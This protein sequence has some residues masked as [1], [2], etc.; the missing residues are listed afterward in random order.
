MAYFYVVLSET[1]GTNEISG[2]EET[3]YTCQK[4]ELPVEIK[5]NTY[6]DISTNYDKYLKQAMN[7]THEKACEKIRNK[8]DK[9]LDVCDIKHINPEHW[10]TFTEQSKQEWREYKQAL[11]DI[12]T[13]E[14]FPYKVVFPKIPTTTEG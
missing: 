12:T 2:Q 4:Y 3:F 14:G 5:A 10:E 8:R 9:L 1:K 11:R 13:Q 6:A 7:Y